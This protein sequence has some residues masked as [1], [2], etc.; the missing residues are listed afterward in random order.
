MDLELVHTVQM[1]IEVEVHNDDEDGDDETA[2]IPEEAV[3]AGHTHNNEEEAT[4][5]EELGYRNCKT[6]HDPTRTWIVH[7]QMYWWQLWQ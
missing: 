7:R 3:A 5:E 1:P 2:T 6:V 4:E